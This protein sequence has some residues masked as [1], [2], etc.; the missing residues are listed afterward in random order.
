MQSLS[1]F[2]ISF[3]FLIFISGCLTIAYIDD[4]EKYEDQINE[5]KTQINNN[6]DNYEAVRDLGIIY[7]KT[8]DY[9]N[10]Q[11]LL[12]KAFGKN[13]ND[14]Q[15]ILYYGLTL[16]FLQLRDEAIQIYCNYTNL[17]PLSAFCSKI[18]GRY[19][20]LTRQQMQ[21]EMRTLLL[22]ET[23][24]T[25]ERI[26]PGKIAVFPFRL[27]TGNADYSSLGRGLA[28]MIITDL[29]QV[30]KIELIE[31]ERIQSLLDE[32][33]LGQTGLVDEK[34]APKFGKLLG[35][36]K[37]VHGSF[38][39]P[40]EDNITLD[41]A[42]WDI[43]NKHFPTFTSQND[44]LGNLF[45]LEKDIVF[46]VIDNMGI[47]L[48]MEE[49]QNIQRIPTKNMQAFMA[50]SKGLEEKDKGNFNASFEQFNA[51]A[52]I[53]PGFSEAKENSSQVNSE[54]QS[55]GTKEHFAGVSGSVRSL[56]TSTDRLVVERLR[57]LNANAGS[58]FNPGEDKRESGEEAANAG[59]DIGIPDLPDPPRPPRN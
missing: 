16:E 3:L 36:G 59:A 55:S 48:T 45:K 1:K 33:A 57:I 23:Q 58:N 21:D 54:N 34:T 41:A 5:L 2:C 50:Y 44:A 7:F 6:P 32:M 24:L 31:R 9:E 14:E 10:A 29:S 22:Q 25:E 17:S 27:I 52:T 40:D 13:E 28:E 4:P 19:R 38:S 49:K 42:F 51:A 47:Q 53:D 26:Q 35:A 11:L 12:K 18:E 8:T 15:T 43:Q 56:S 37:M 39:I 46:K 30:K 20:W